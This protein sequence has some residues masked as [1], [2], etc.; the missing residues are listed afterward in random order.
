MFNEYEWF[1]TVGIR[2]AVLLASHTLYDIVLIYSMRLYLY[3]FV[4]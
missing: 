3:D 4:L 2:V 1:V